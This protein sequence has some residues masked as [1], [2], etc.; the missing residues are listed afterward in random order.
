MPRRGDIVLLPGKGVF[1][2][3]GPARGAPPD[4]GLLDLGAL[5]GYADVYAIPAHRLQ[6]VP[7]PSVEAQERAARR[8]GARTSH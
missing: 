3:L 1:V 2:V 4:S 6:T 5:E 7:R 8:T